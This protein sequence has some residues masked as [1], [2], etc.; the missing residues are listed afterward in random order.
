M[1]EQIDG[2]YDKLNGDLDV[3]IDR[4][5]DVLLSLHNNSNTTSPAISPETRCSPQ[6]MPG[7]DTASLRDASTSSAENGFVQRQSSGHNDTET[8]LRTPELT[9]SEFSAGSPRH[10]RSPASTRNSY[11]PSR[12]LSQSSSPADPPRHSGHS[13]F[14]YDFHR[15]RMSKGQ[16]LQIT[17][18]QNEQD[19]SRKSQSLTLPPP[20]MDPMFSDLSEESFALT[21]PKHTKLEEDIISDERA[22]FE[23]S[24]FTGAAV[25][26]DM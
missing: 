23:R 2:I 18:E 17:L 12:K 8:L 9:A 15:P 11:E 6:L 3:K 21:R 25:L 24:I 19:L 20:A 13:S 14:G 10:V 5:H 22:K 26:C 4:I 1:A 16:S 7:I